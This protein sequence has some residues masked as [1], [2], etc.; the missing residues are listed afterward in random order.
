VKYNHVIF[1]LDNSGSM[2][3]H[4]QTPKKVLIDQLHEIRKN[5]KPD[6]ITLVSCYEFATNCRNIIKDSTVVTALD[7]LTNYPYYANGASTNLYDAFDEATRDADSIGPKLVITITDGE[8]N[9]TRRLGSK[10]FADYVQYLNSHPNWTVSFIGPSSVINT[11]NMVDRGN[12]HVW[13]GGEQELVETSTIL[14]R[15]IQN[16]YTKT[17]SAGLTK[18]STFI[19]ADVNQNKVRGLRK[20]VG[21][22]QG[23]VQQP[24]DIKTFATKLNKNFNRGDAFYELTKPEMVQKYKTLLLQDH[25]TGDILTGDVRTALGI[26]M[27]SNAE[28]TPGNLKGYKVFVQSTSVNR[29]L[30]PGTLVLVKK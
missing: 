28:V 2:A 7:V 14:T 24:T 13:E 15:S 12:L 3:R 18:T 5:Q 22:V 1:V 23:L 20:T 9:S 6:Q 19:Q 17:L 27:N 4:R 21:F 29:K 26:P 8:H 11:L 25:K 10:Q 30:V 16:Y